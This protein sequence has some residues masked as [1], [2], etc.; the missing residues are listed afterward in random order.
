MNHSNDDDNQ[1]DISY[2]HIFDLTSIETDNHNE[3]HNEKQQ[4]SLETI[5]ININDNNIGHMSPETKK[6]LLD[7]I[8]ECF[9]YVSCNEDLSITSEMFSHILT[10][11]SNF[12]NCD[13]GF[14]GELCINEEDNKYFKYFST[15]SK[16]DDSFKLFNKK[17][18]DIYLKDIIQEKIIEFNEPIVINDLKV[19]TFCA[20]PLLKQEKLM[21]IICFAREHSHHFTEEDLKNINILSKFV[22]NILINVKNM[23]ELDMRKMNFISNMSHEVR[24][25]LNSILSSIT[26]LNSTDLTSQQIDYLDILKV[27]SQQLMDI[28]NDILD[29]SKIISKGI[30]LNMEPIS[31]VNCITNVFTMFDL[32]AKQKKIDFYINYSN[33]ELPDLI[34][35]DNI[36][37][38]QILI[39]IISNAVKFTKE[40][41]KIELIVKQVFYENDHCELLF[42]LTDTGIGIKKQN[43][44]KVFDAFNQLDK[45]YLNEISGVGLGLSITKHLVQ[46]FNG[47]IHIES[48]YNKG[49]KVVVKIPFKVYT[50]K[51]DV[52]QLIQFFTNKHVLI[53]DQNPKERFEIFKYL[54]TYNIHSLLSS[55]IEETIEYL[56][57]HKDLDFIIMDSFENLEN[58]QFKNIFKTD[59]NTKVIILN[60]LSTFK[61]FKYDY[62][63]MRPITKD[64]IYNLLNNIYNCTSNKLVKSHSYIKLDNSYYNINNHL[65]QNSSEIVYR[66]PQISKAS[67]PHSLP[68]SPPHSPPQTPHHS[69]QH[70]NSKN[71]E[72]NNKIK[73]LI[74]EDN[75]QNQIVIREILNKLQYSNV[76]LAEDG[77]EAYVKL[78]QDDYDIVLMDL[79]MPI[80]SGIEVVSKYKHT[81]NNSNSEKKTY[82]I[83]VTASISDK[84][85]QECIH[86]G[87]DGFIAKPINMNDLNTILNVIKD[88]I[89]KNHNYRRNKYSQ[90]NN[91]NQTFEYN[92][93]MEYKHGGIKIKMKPNKKRSNKNKK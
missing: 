32:K 10:K 15:Y 47:T 61:H 12:I 84:I 25:P 1:T 54:N 73:I 48:D 6:S 87:M 83:A 60:E 36:R 50:K 66:F 9:T 49:T 46:L 4:I 23:E 69:P 13:Y 63:L 22:C 76:S 91:R 39:N 5:N 55:T 27:C 43:L 28:V 88:E 85:K 40:G 19:S 30:K 35:A 52:E 45:N 33:E 80:M 18:L 11:I 59:E 86:V 41:G 72:T 64:K 7:I 92:N 62:K 14:I 67:P 56:T 16:S 17:N 82:F 53:F 42:T 74:A 31:I 58:E 81:N 26:L 3:N 34:L 75:K 68:H 90:L 8:D 79:K 89:I 44:G 65:L 29:F 2:C 21:G 20:Y 51:T 57:I 37:I 71:N 77:Y 78:I 24:T 93:R 38:H 70:S